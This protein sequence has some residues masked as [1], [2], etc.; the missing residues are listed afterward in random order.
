MIFLMA[1]ASESY[2]LHSTGHDVIIFKR[3]FQCLPVTGCL[4][5]GKPLAATFLGLQRRVT[6]VGTDWAEIPTG[7]TV[8]Q[9]HPHSP[10]SDQKIKINTAAPKK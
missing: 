2:I 7:A 4:E 8:T 6:A 10:V 5:S 1:A 9:I 3:I